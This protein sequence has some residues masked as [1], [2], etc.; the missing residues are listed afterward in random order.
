MI[1]AERCT[2]RSSAEAIARLQLLITGADVDVMAY[3]SAY[4]LALR[5]GKYD[6]RRIW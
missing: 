5:F 3:Q 2:V 1:R 6:F 4:L